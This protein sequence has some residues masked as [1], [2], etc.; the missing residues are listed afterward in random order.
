MKDGKKISRGITLISLVVTIIVLL[1][2]S[3]VALTM[4]TGEN[5][6]LSM[7]KKAR[8]KTEEAQKDEEQKL[9]MLE[10]ISSDSETEYKVSSDSETEYKGV[11]IPAGYTPT[12]RA[13]E[14]EVNKGLVITDAKG[15]EWVWIEV[16]NDGTGPNYPENATDDQIESALSI[17]VY[18]TTS[19]PGIISRPSGW[20]DRWYD[21]CGTIYDGTNDYAELRYIKKQSSEDDDT[22]A[23]I[24]LTEQAVPYYGNIYTNTA[25]TSVLN[26]DSCDL[27]GDTKYYV[28]ITDKLNDNKGCGLTYSEYNNKKSKM[29]QSIKKNGGFFIGRYEVGYLEGSKRTSGNADTAPTQLPV[30]K[31]NAYPYNCIT[32]SQAEKLAESFSTGTSNKTTSLMFGLQ[33]DL[34]LKFLK[35]KET[36]IN[37][38]N[39]TTWGNY[40]NAEFKIDRGEWAKNS[41]LGTWYKFNDTAHNDKNYFKDKTKLAYNSSVSDASNGRVLLTTGAA[42]RNCKCNIY[43]LAGNVWEWTLERTSHSVGYC[44]RRGGSFFYNGNTN[45]ASIRSV[46]NAGYWTTGTGVR[47]SLY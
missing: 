10:A 42:D 1:I 17:Y 37:I 14:D 5:G 31:Q 4:L 13:G 43:D 33:W 24:R 7:A 20:E 30:I 9:L 47:P 38:T 11:K 45:P 2:L 35:E 12:K 29:L 19:N 25:L 28:K 26:N 32:C 46:G 16:P 23:R 39:S 40:L 3:G 27:T 15:N 44:T 36:T 6:I 41:V 34:V 18:G 8:E 22:E 21:K